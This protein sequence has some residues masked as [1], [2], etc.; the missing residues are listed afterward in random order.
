MG[1]KPKEEPKYK[2]EILKMEVVSAPA[3]QAMDLSSKKVLM[4]IAPKDF[5][6]KEFS[7]PKKVLEAKGVKI[8]VASTS[9]KSAIGMYGMKVMPDLTLKEAR[10]ADYDAV[11][12][13]GGDG[14]TALFDDPQALSLAIEA[15]KNNKV[16]GAICVAPVILARAGIL[17]GKKATVS[18]WGKGDL[19]KAGATCT[20]K[21][22]EVD[23]NII[24]GSGP[25]AS[26]DFG[27]AI[28]N[29][30]QK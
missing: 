3:P 4:I 27:K 16:I 29:A 13:I 24:T 11:L 18:S 21:G 8:T 19:K 30:L 5:Q 26:A 12:F 10:A 1:N 23:G 28:L 2:L 9:K 25:S 6:D 22:I 14:M 7:E 15:N 17:E 20:G